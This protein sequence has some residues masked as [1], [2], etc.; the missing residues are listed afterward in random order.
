M[1]VAC[2]GNWT[3]VENLPS[4]GQ[5]FS[6]QRS[7][8]VQLMIMIHV[9]YIKCYVIFAGTFWQKRHPERALW[10]NTPSTDS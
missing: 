10:S 3:L 1:A 6:G 5:Q 8:E 7:L 4:Q 2:E 9:E